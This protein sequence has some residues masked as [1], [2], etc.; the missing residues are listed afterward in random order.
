MIDFGLQIKELGSELDSMPGTYLA[1]AC[2]SKM[3]LRLQRPYLGYLFELKL[4][5]SLVLRHQK[6][7]Q[8]LHHG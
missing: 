4:D 5:F 8:L 2:D 6:L 1:S 3:V 7:V